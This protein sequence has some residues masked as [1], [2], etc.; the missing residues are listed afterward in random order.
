MCVEPNTVHTGNNNNMVIN[1]PGVEHA[2]A[3]SVHN[4]NRTGTGNENVVVNYSRPSESKVT[5]EAYYIRV[6]E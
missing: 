5:G 6:S 4:F 2:V 3:E 1:K